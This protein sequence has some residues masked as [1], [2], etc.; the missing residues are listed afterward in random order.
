YFNP[1]ADLGETRRQDWFSCACCPPNLLRLL[2]SIPGYFYCISQRGVYVNFYAT[3]EAEINYNGLIIQINQKTE[4]PWSGDIKLEINPMKEEEFSI[5]LRVPEWSEGAK[6]ILDN[7]KIVSNSSGYVEVRK[8]WHQGDRLKVI[9]KMPI[10]S[11][12]S[13]PH[14]SNN[15]ARIAL[16]RGPIVYCLE[17]IDNPEADLWNIM[18]TNLSK[19]TSKYEPKLLGGI[20]TISGEGTAFN[21][22]VWRNKLYTPL[23]RLNM[24]NKRIRIKAIPYYGWGN[25]EPGPMVIWIPCAD[26]MKSITKKG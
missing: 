18:I 8:V 21:Q 16:K 10:R 17:Q 24:K 3:S 19:L 1:L 20:V 6:I 9:F 14:V 11:I 23:E 4:Y 5:F 12:V 15:F 22:M 2:L 13:H 26:L 7:K 25:R